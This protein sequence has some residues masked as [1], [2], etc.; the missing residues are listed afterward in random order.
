MRLR[1][2]TDD[3]GVA[4]E[5]TNLAPGQAPP[6]PVGPA[7]RP[8]DDADGLAERGWGLA[9]VA[10]VSDDL[11]V[12]RRGEAMVVRARRALRAGE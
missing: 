8:A 11:S 4:V 2:V 1:V 10:A 6:D 3:E 5:V 7:G 9:I 12:E